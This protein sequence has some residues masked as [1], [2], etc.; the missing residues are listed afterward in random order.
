MKRIPDLLSMSRIALC[1]PLL[2]VDA[3]T[4]PFW[5]LYL[6]AGLTDLTYVPWSAFES[7]AC[8]YN[9]KI[10]GRET[11]DYRSFGEADVKTFCQIFDRLSAMGITAPAELYRQG[12]MEYLK[13]YMYANDQDNLNDLF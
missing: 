8:W 3:M 12:I 5:V 6:I 9:C 1:L 7:L 4:L 2:M 10:A 11:E 13:C